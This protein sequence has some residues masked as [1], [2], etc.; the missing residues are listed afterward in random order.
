M[1]AHVAQAPPHQQRHQPSEAAAPVAV[2]SRH[3]GGEGCVILL[4]SLWLRRA[5][6]HLWPRQCGCT[7]TTWHVRIIWQSFSRA[8][9]LMQALLRPRIIPVWPCARFTVRLLC[10]WA[11][12]QAAEVRRQ[13]ELESALHHQMVLQKKLQEQLEVTDLPSRASALFS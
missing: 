12:A 7:C 1:Q 5:S 9:C 8:A 3:A 2:T 10:R 11:E 4:K 6:L 13:S